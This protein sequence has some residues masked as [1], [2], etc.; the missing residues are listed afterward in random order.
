MKILITGS[1]GFVGGSLGRYAASA[2][3]EVLG[4][5]RATQRPLDWPGKYISADVVTADLAPVIREFAPD[6]IFHAAG[7]ASVGASFKTPI[8]DLRASLFSWANL[9]HSAH[10]SGAHPLICFPSSGAVYGRLDSLPV[11]ETASLR[12]ISPYGFHKVACELLA[13]EYATCFSQRVIV[14]R[15]FSLFG[16]YQRRLLV[17]EIFRQ[18]ASSEE[19]VWLQGTGEETRDYLHVN[20]MAAAVVM[21]A[22]DQ[23][24]KMVKGTYELI[25]LASGSETRVIDLAKQM[26][27]VV[28]PQKKIRC[29]GVR[30]PGDPERWQSDISKLRSLLPNWNPQPLN[31]G[32]AT[33]IAAWQR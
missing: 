1:R 16:E 20:D 29:R 8:D 9:L 19:T 21:L 6:T 25:N 26:G 5:S 24:E 3:H 27:S 22:E 12:P 18:L 28:A 31:Q 32:L 15:L 10:R 17:W 33:C 30:R 23:T 11:K 2:G 13:Q 4:I 14:C 7:T